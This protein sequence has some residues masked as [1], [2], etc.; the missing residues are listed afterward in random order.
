MTTLSLSTVTRTLACLT[1]AAFPVLARGEAVVISSENHPALQR[2]LSETPQADKDANGQLSLE[3]YVELLPQQRPNDPE[4]PKAP[5]LPVRPNGDLVIHEFEDN[6]LGQNPKWSPVHAT[7]VKDSTLGNLGGN[8]QREGDAFNRDLQSGT[9]MMRRRVGPFEGKLFLTTIGNS[10]RAVGSLR[11]PIFLIEQDYILIRMSGG[12]H[13]GRVCVNLHTGQGI[14]RSATGHNDDYFENVAMDVREFRG[15]FARLELRDQHRGLWGH[16]NVDEILM[17]S[18][19]GEAR[20]VNNRPPPPI[21]TGGLIISGSGRNQGVLKLENGQLS[22]EDKPLVGEAFLAVNP[23]PENAPRLPGAV[24]LL[25]GEVWNAEVLT[26]EGAG[27]K[28]ILNIRSQIFGAQKIPLSTLS[29]MEFVAG[30]PGDP[31]EPGTFYRKDGEPLPGSLIWVRAK[32][33]AIRSP[34][35]V[36][37]VPRAAALRFV[38]ARPQPPARRSGDEIGLTDGSL[39][40]GTTSFEGNQLLIQHETL[41]ELKVA[42]NAVHYLRR[43]LPGLTWLDNVPR[44]VMEAIGPALPPPAPRL[45]TKVNESHARSLRIMPHTVLRFALPAPHGPALFRGQLHPVPGNRARLEVTVLDGDSPVWSSKVET[46]SGPIPLALSL[47]G[48]EELTIKVA[49]DGP[50]TFPCG[51]DLRDAHV[52]RTTNLKPE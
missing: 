50:L 34:L 4:N 44:T 37:P 42:W 22:C 12:A 14:V 20:V 18:K 30:A 8:W 10:Q 46:A 47:P 17:T 23:M 5:L 32:D 6:N 31:R 51:V 7:P 25:N 19:H 26:V 45:S 36:I 40:F 39:L 21:P 15:Q 9:K 38:L 49:F 29:S 24:H 41:G 35:G 3:E 52:I 48:G 33:I 13:P 28:K 16:L 1:A 2:A 11:S 27:R 43:N